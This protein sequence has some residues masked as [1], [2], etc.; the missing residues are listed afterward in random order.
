MGTILRANCSKCGYQ[1]KLFVG[2]GFRDCE[3]ATALAV[4]PDNQAF[5]QALHE[6]ARFQISRDV[7]V[8][9]RCRQLFSAPYVTYWPTEGAPRS[10]A[11]ACPVCGGLPTRLSGDRKS[12]PCP[13]CGQKLA[14]VPCG[15]WD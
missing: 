8:C 9:R 2:G 11:S 13:S 12:T 14:L 5:A 1:V 6:G 3:A 7:S 4:A 10:I 15:H